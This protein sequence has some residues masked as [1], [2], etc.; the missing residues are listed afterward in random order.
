MITLSYGYLKPQ[1][2]VDAGDVFFPAMETNIQKVNDHTHNG[3]NS[4]LIAKTTQNILSSN[5]V[6]APIGGGLYMQVMTMPS[7]YLYDS[8]NM[9]FR[10]SDGSVFYPTIERV[11]TN[12]YRIFIND[13]TLNA[14][15]IYV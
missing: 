14:I 10:L 9:C 5:W 8:C 11:S 6:V 7:P 1:N 3:V 12:S 4:A 15:G 2:G 13:N